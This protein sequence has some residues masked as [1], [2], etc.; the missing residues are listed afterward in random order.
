MFNS[1]I[2]TQAELPTTGKLLRSTFFSL[3]AAGV[4]LVTVVLPAEYAID[5]TG[6]GRVLGLTEMGEIKTQL[7]AEAKADQE[8]AVAMEQQPMTRTTEP[9]NPSAPAQV[10]VPSAAP[11]K[12]AEPQK[13][14]EALAP[15]WKEE[16]SFTLVPGQGAEV[17]LV[18]DEGAVAEFHWTVDGGVANYDLHG[19]GG[20]KSIAYQK[21]RGV[22]G[23][24]GKL[25]A[26]FTGNHGWFWRNRE[27]Q[28][29][30]VTLRVRGDYLELKRL[31]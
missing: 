9:E 2:P 28:P 7:E 26:A 25:E 21:G 18:M 16:I 15:T 3:V 20:G 1:D 4:I 27:N 13:T 11:A 10:A 14:A 24:E 12:P 22:P 17:K 31:I 23:D 8:Q 5:P 30:K 29:I 19:D 6:I